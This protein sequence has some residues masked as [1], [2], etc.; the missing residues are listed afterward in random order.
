MSAG[1]LVAG[2]EATVTQKRYKRW[3]SREP[4]RERLTQE[5]PGQGTGFRAWQW[6]WQ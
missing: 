3:P 4:G 1:R 6:Q 2:G 5:M